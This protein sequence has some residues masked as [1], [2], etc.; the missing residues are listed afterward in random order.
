MA[1]YFQLT[2]LPIS[3]ELSKHLAVAVCYMSV[4]L[5]IAMSKF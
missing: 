1:N 4:M 2:P 5:L 3:S